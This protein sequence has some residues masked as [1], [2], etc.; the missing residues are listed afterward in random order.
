MADQGGFPGSVLSDN[1]VIVS[2]VTFGLQDI[3]N[4]PRDTLALNKVILA[5][6]IWNSYY[7]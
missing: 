5:F 7:S 2:I 4:G 3:L 1:D 6:N